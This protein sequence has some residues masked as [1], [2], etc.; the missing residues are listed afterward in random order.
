MRRLKAQRPLARAV[1]VLLGLGFASTSA[2]TAER[3]VGNGPPGDDLTRYEIAEWHDKL[4][5][6]TNS[7]NAPGGGSSGLR[8]WAM[9]ALAMF[10]ASNTIDRTYAPYAVSPAA[11]PG[12]IDPKIASKR[13]AV[14]KAAQVV[15]DGL[16]APPPSQPTSALAHLRRFAHATNLRFTP[17]HSIRPRPPTSTASR[18]ATSSAERFSKTAPAT[19]IRRPIQRSSTAQTGTSINTAFPI[20]PIHLSPPATPASAPSVSPLSVWPA[21]M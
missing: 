16:F 20:S 10:E 19:A 13:V 14:A 21:G 1:I 7:L 15:L 6:S 17:Q 11:V 3:N 2:L 4:Y 8:G 9:M 18:S 12:E 5:E